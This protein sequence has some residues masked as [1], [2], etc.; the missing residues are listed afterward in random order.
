MGATLAFT[1]GGLVAGASSAHA[2]DLPMTI[3]PASGTNFTGASVNT[4][5]PCSAPATHIQVRVVG[6]GFGNSA[7]D[8]ATQGAGYNMTSNAPLSSY[9][10]NPLGGKLVP[11][12]LNFQAAADNQV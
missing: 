1:C 10:D 12:G 9:A 3:D 11:L 8:P 7:F 4:P 6:S 2:V 5:Q